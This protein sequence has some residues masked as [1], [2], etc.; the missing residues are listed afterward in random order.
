M[1]YPN[2]E[3]LIRMG[4]TVFVVYLGIYYWQSISKVLVMLCSAFYPVILGCAIAYIANIPMAFFERRLAWMDI[5]P[6]QLM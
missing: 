3:E 2:K 5:H 1:R 6:L 4:L